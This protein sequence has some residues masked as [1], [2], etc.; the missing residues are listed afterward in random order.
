M[1]SIGYRKDSLDAYGAWNYSFEGRERMQV[2]KNRSWMLSS[3][4][5]FNTLPRKSDLRFT[6]TDPRLKFRYMRS[7]V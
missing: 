1:V 2:Q 4:Y 5:S 3:S 7:M 6:R